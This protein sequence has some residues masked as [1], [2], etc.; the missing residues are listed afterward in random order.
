MKFVLD[1]NAYSRLMQNR[2]SL[3]ELVE[4]ADLVLLPTVAIGE[5][6][7]GFHLGSRCES[8]R[9]G[10]NEFLCLPGIE[11]VPIDHDIAERYGILVCTLKEK[12]T[13]IPTNDIWIAA[14][15]LELGARLISYD[16]HFDYVPGLITLSP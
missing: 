4:H 5:L 8:N 13:P 7:A 6:Y 12:G 15:S 1:T 3:T 11:I 16:T 10:L 2:S 14:T 9:A